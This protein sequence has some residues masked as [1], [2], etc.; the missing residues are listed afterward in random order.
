LCGSKLY[1]RLSEALGIAAEPVMARRQVT[2]VQRI[3]LAIEN[4]ID[5]AQGQS[6]PGDVFGVKLVLGE[7]E[8]EEI[9]RFPI[10]PTAES[11]AGGRGGEFRH[12]C[13]IVSL[14]AVM[15]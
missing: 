10:R 6:N 12:A 14:G 4:S 7:S 13:A 11:L 1:Q 15:G 5:A 2:L 8:L 3:S 9:A